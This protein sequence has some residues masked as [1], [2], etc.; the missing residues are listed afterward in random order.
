MYRAGVAMTSRSG[1]RSWLRWSLLAL[2]LGAITAFLLWTRREDRWWLGLLLIGWG[3]LVAGF[4][5][6]FDRRGRR[7]AK[8][9]TPTPRP[10]VFEIPAALQAPPPRAVRSEVAARMVRHYRRAYP[11]LLV[12]PLLLGVFWFR[13]TDWI[14]AYAG[15]A[16]VQAM[17]LLA[18]VL[19][20]V[21]YV[22]SNV[23][24]VRSLLRDGAVVRGVVAGV[25][26]M[27]NKAT[28]DFSLAGARLRVS[29][30][31]DEASDLEPE[32]QVPILVASGSSLVAMVIAPE[33]MVVARMRR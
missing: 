24:A 1:K 13:R 4:F 15:L 23:R 18:L 17:V 7:L 27:R 8:S 31:L 12:L 32:Y 22:E 2:N 28:V 26:P 25:S 3:W 21:L 10:H 33:K 30:P 5:R 14:V 6:W 9:D 19:A 11:S 20:A 16:I 29:V